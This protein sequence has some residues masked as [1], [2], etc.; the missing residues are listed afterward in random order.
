MDVGVEI[1]QYKI[2]EHIGRGGMADVWSARDQRLN[3]MVAIKTIAQSLTTDDDPV[4]MFKQEAQFIARMEHPHILPIYDFG[5][6][7]GQL[8]IVMRYVAGGSLEDMLRRGP[9]PVSEVLRLGSA[10]AEALDYAHASKV[11]HLDLKPPNVL[12]DSHQVPYLADF[13]LATVMVEGKAVNP[14]SGTL[15][16]MAPEQLTSE[17]LD[18][19]ADIYSFCIVVYHMLTGQ[20]PFEGATP[21]AIKQ[22]QFNEDL[23]DPSMLNSS[24]PAYFGD[25]LRRGTALDP[26]H[27]PLKLMHVIEDMREIIADSTAISLDFSNLRAEKKPQTEPDVPLPVSDDVSALLEA[28]DIYSRAR[29][30]WADGNGR[31]LLGVT[32]FM[33]MNGYYMN[34]EAHGLDL[35]RSGKQ[36]LLRGALEYDQ[37]IMF[38]W[39]QLDDD[40]RRWVCLHALRSGNAPA[41]VRALYRLETVP[42]ADAPQIPRLVAQALQIETNEQARLAALQVLGT[43]AKLQRRIGGSIR[44]RILSEKTRL[45]VQTED[46][47]D[48]DWHDIVFTY[49]IDLLVADIAMDYGM[50]R[51]AEFAARIIGRIRSITAVSHLVEQ[52]RSGR[53]RALRALALV[54]DEAPTLPSPVNPQGR[55]YAWSA[56]TLRRMTEQPFNLILRYLL[57]VL[58]AWLGMGFHVFSVF[59]TQSV[60]MQQ[61]WANTIAMGL[62]FG[63]IAG[64]VSILAGEFSARLRGFWPWYVRLV[65]ALFF[66]TLAGSAA[67]WAWQWFFLTQ[68]PSAELCLYGGFWMAM[69]FVLAAQFNLHSFI[70]VPLTAA[71]TYFP[72]FVTFYTGALKQDFWPITDLADVS[73]DVFWQD[74]PYHPFG[75]FRFRE[76]FEALLW[77]D[78]DFQT[79]A[80]PDQLYS[81]AI[82]FA[83]LIAVG[84]FLPL[85]TRDIGDI[86]RRVNARMA[87][88]R[89]GESPETAPTVRV[90]AL[91]GGIEHVINPESLSTEIDFDQGGRR[92]IANAATERD[93]NQGAVRDEGETE[94]QQ[95]SD[96]STRELPPLEDETELRKPSSKVDP[97]TRPISYEEIRDD[98]DPLAGKESKDE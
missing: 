82:P 45:K 85:I 65:F 17:V 73:L 63:V 6:F 31:F 52:Q 89:P 33:L 20:L 18:H 91:I 56:N 16:Y 35:D 49:E 11:I 94:P 81:V 66:G 92:D 1:N 61:R 21:L 53:I 4:N 86:V 15:L 47:R 14:G 41:R 3:R 64:A 62:V 72:V 54:R 95:L 83:L 28:V 75:I 32:H 23:P 27:R 98:F 58:G 36:M 77:Y 93:M 30:S 34:A 39:E 19:R 5:E 70:A 46:H 7:E 74:S 51:V 55:F 84:G 29:H 80:I 96:L 57:A 12:M 38:W 44:S 8:Y 24:V 22:M 25:I 69:G 68:Q 90:P 13:G 59:R 78:Y 71:M 60:F 76:R 10:V 79:L 50:P 48:D 40:N 97:A 43:R 26:D 87:A 88:A 37:E 67:W 42:D 2:V 9:L